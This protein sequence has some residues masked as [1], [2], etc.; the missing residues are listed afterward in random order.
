MDR[1][2][3]AYFEVRGMHRDVHGTAFYTY[4]VLDV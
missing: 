4:A 1:R 2:I 3:P